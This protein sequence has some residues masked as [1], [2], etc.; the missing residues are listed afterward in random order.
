VPGQVRSAITALADRLIDAGLPR[1]LAEN[2]VTTWMELHDYSVAESVR[3]TARINLDDL[4]P[5][6]RLMRDPG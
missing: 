6:P 1:T 3:F 5:V 2:A 4:P